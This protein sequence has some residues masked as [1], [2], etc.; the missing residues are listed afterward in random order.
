MPQFTMKL[1]NFC[2]HFLAKI[3]KLQVHLILAA[4]NG[5]LNTLKV[6]INQ[7]ESEFIGHAL[8]SAAKG[9]HLE[10]I[11]VLIGIRDYEPSADVL[12]DAGIAALYENKFDCFN[13]STILL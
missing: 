9:G 3:R 13:I 10:C 8:V 12:V 1:K 4:E 6:L 11:K 7:A 2:S 5:R